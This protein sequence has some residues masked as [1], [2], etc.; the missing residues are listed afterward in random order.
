MTDRRNFLRYCVGTVAYLSVPG[1][2]AAA[3]G[4]LR[5]NVLA[6]ND[7]GM[8]LRGLEFGAAEADRSARLFGWSVRPDWRRSAGTSA[9][10]DAWIM[11]VGGE[12]P[13]STGPVLRV[14][15]D[16]RVAT[17]VTFMIAPCSSAADVW[18]PAFERYGAQQ[19]NDR[20]R[21]ATGTGMTSGAWLGWLA[22]KILAESA[23]RAQSSDGPALVRAL[24]DPATHFDGHKGIPLRFDAQRRLIHPS[25]GGGAR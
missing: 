19:L 11:A 2:R 13:A 6:G 16:S 17:D 20:F 7:D 8:L 23:L 1:S 10:A 15:C 5:V 22:F 25:S 4:T 24:T 12:A 18:D 3:A 21:S 9:D 14:V